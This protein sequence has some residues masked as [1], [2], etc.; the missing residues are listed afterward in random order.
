MSDSGIA[1]LLDVPREVIRGHLVVAR[2][3]VANAGTEPRTMSVRLHLAEGDVAL[4][5]SDPTG[6]TRRLA[7]RYQVDS[8]PRDVEVPPGAAVGAG[9]D[10]LGTDAGRL[11]DR[12]G[13][14]RVSPIYH[15]SVRE[16]PV[17]GPASEVA[18]R[19]GLQEDERSVT[20]LLDPAVV[21][22]ALALG[23]VDPGSPAARALEE[24]AGLA[25]GSPGAAVAALVVAAGAARRG[26]GTDRLREVLEGL[27]DDSVGWVVTAALPPAADPADPLVAVSLEV[28]AG[29]DTPGAGRS[30]AMVQGLPFPAVS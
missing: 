14:H 22:E 23:D 7:G 16:E 2:L 5:V 18:V 4:D 10:L 24:V 19:G 20:D 6:R 21:G 9:V 26:R 15:P 17:R 3:T 25:P 11:F 12:P 30:R 28:L 13:I 29:R 27:P 8:P 1:I